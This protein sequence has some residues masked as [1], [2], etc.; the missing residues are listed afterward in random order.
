MHRIATPVIVISLLGAPGFAA[1]Q[2]LGR[3]EARIGETDMRWQTITT[4]R[5]SGTEASAALR[6]GPRLTEL[7]IQGYPGAEFTSANAISV[8]LRYLGQFAPDAVPMSVDI[9]YMPDGMGGPFWTSN[10]AT[11]V[12][13]VRVLELDVW[14]AFGRIDLLFAGELCLRKI[15]SAATDP[16]RCQEVTG[17]IETELFVDYGMSG[18][19]RRP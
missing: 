16:E 11:V 19:T 12:P 5:N 13:T 7:Q 1:A 18:G 4:A 17:R 2:G 10:G 8:D 14:G 15:I 6:F 9:L 3:I